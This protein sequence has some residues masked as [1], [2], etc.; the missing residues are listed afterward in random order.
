[1]AGVKAYLAVGLGTALGSV[2]RYGVSLWALAALGSAFA[3][4]TL[5]VNALGSLLIGWLA[6]MASHRGESVW[7]RL[8]PLLVT[9]YCA[10]FTTFSLFSLE[11]L[12]LLQSEPKLA[13][14]YVLLSLVMWLCGV[15][16]GER[17]AQR[18]LAKNQ[19]R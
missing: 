16:L 14:L 2:C 18:R 12:S 7:A 5:I 17:L 13:L 6:T 3:W 15:A 1:M 9:G 19:N 11:V 10:G 4:G 8:Q